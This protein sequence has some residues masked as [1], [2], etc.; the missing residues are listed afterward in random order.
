MCFF[1]V[2]II[3]LFISSLYD[4]HYFDKAQNLFNLVIQAN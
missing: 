3:Y 1:L 4:L 2:D